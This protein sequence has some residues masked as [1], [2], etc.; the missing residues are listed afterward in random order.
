M[1]Y[2]QEPLFRIIDAATIEKILETAYALLQKP[3][4]KVYND[5]ALKIFEEGGC[6]VNHETRIV[7]IP[8]SLVEW[9]IRETPRTFTLHNLQGEPQA[10]LESNHFHPYPGTTAISVY[11]YKKR[12][13]RE[14]MT[15]DLKQF[16]KVV[17]HLPFI[18]LQSAFI[19][20]DVP[21]NFTDIYRLAV[22][23]KH[24][25]KPIKT[26]V[27]TTKDSI[28]VM[29]DLLFAVSGGE[30]T[31]A[32]KPI[33]FVSVNCDPPFMWNDF[34]TEVLIEC[35]ASKIPL[36][37]GSMPI[38]GAAAPVT[39]IGAVIQHA[40]ESM[41]SIVLSQLVRPGAPGLYGS[42][43][44]IFDIRKGTTPMG[45]IETHM[46]NSA[47][48][49]V[50][51]YLKIPTHLYLGL[52]DAKCI[53]AQAGFEA[54][55]GI[56]IGALSGANL[57][58]VG[59]MNFET[60]LSP[61][62]IVIANEICGMAERLVRGIEHAPS[63]FS[64]TVWEEVGH[65]QGFIQ[66]L[67]TIKHFK[68]EQFNVSD[69]V[70]RSHL[71]DWIARGSKDCTERAHGIVQD[72][73]SRETPKTVSSKVEEEIDRIVLDYAKHLGIPKERIPRDFFEN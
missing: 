51:K 26:S 39:L 1:Q 60:A 41:S 56:L 17:S 13:F 62:N 3:G 44:I 14:A 27:F 61:E 18:K 16:L 24:T 64:T 58:A 10:L 25:N 45:A 28:S 15:S 55:M 63:D 8:R 65:T 71:D 49:Q 72:I 40:A 22:H 36:S 12:V 23:L 53:D 57:F 47:V 68:Q 30:D 69:I 54:A 11:D 5:R 32:K 2:P 33:G 48:A 21:E 31:C 7:K 70:D 37:R 52:T 4:F 42:S 59:M 46:F 34:I 29:K 43:P 38:S 19:C 50:G 67:H 6:E 73:L 35:A 66:I 20:N 9:A